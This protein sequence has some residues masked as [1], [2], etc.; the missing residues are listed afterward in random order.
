MTRIQT[1]RPNR[2]RMRAYRDRL[3]AQGLRPV[4]V[5]LP[6]VRNRRFAAK[7]RRQSRLVARGTG[8]RAFQA[9]IERSADLAEW[10]T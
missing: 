10:K 6:D 9:L 8:D 7:A 4:Q 2:N 3:R 1:A 5:W